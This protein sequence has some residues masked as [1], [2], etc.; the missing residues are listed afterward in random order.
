MAKYLSVA[1]NRKQGGPGIKLVAC[2]AAWLPTI[3][4]V[5]SNIKVNQKCE[6][7]G[8]LDRFYDIFFAFNG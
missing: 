4:H 7:M 3:K 2:N 5:S 6:V 8:H 1:K